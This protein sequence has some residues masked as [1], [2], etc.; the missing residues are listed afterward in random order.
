MGQISSGNL[1]RNT[2]L[3]SETFCDGAVDTV[4][5]PDQGADGNVIPPSALSAIRHANQNICVNTQKRAYI[6]GDASPAAPPITCTSWIQADCTIRVRHSP[7]LML[8]KEKWFVS[9][10]EVEYV[11]LGRHVLASLGL[12]N[13]ELMTA[14]RSRLGREFDV[15]RLLK[16]KGYEDNASANPK[17]PSM[18]SMLQERDLAAHFIAMERWRS[19][20]WRTATFMWIS[21]KTPMRTCQLH[22]MHWCGMD[23]TMG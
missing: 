1:G 14:A 17:N 7:D 19:I 6:F 22:S 13:Q 23:G 8:H 3:F 5:L 4:I 11:Y 15:P 20:V 10:E 18:H 21:G 2:S 12:D 9:V 16:D